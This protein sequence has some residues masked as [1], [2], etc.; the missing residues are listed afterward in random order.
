MVLEELEDKI[1]SQDV[2]AEVREML[3]KIQSGSGA[4]SAGGVHITTESAMAV[5]DV[6]LRNPVFLT[7]TSTHGFCAGD[8]QCLMTRAPFFSSQ[9][10]GMLASYAVII[11]QT[12]DAALGDQEY[13]KKTDL[14]QLAEMIL[15]LMQNASTSN[16]KF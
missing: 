1:E 2:Q 10:L 4:I 8:C 3:S 9:V 5:S 6:T 12:R 11:Y 14:P 15:G 16:T 13:A 7:F